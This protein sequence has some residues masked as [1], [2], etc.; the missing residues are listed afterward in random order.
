MEQKSHTALI[1]ED[2]ELN[3]EILQEILSEDYN[4]YTA[5]NG[6]EGMKVLR[7][8][9]TEIN[10][11]LLDIQMPVMNGYEVL[12]AVS[13][14]PQLNEIPIVVT[15]GNEES[16]E[17]LKCLKMGASDFIRKPY[18]PTLVLLRLGIIIH[19]SE[20]TKANMQK[21]Q[22]INNISHEIRTPLNAIMGF[23]QLLGMP[24]DVID[25]A[26][27]EKYVEVITNNTKMLLWM[28]E[29][30][31][32]LADSD[33]KMLNIVKDNT[34]IKTACKEA[35]ATIESCCPPE[36]E[37]NFTSDVGDDFLVNT[38]GNRVQQI[39]IKLLSN[40]C[41][42]TSEGS[43]NL[44]CSKDEKADVVT[45]SVSDSGPGVPSS[46]ADYIFERFTKLDAFK[47]GNGLGLC[48]ARQLSAML[49][50]KVYLDTEYKPGARFV[51]ELPL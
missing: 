34:S 4:V 28:I 45:I 13:E 43:I 32:I 33:N 26:D 17:E 40:A 2:N 23:S 20:S 44:H 19:L 50:G 9:R 25:D 38:D 31:L 51:L 35:V 7:E 8:H 42:W 30:A 27:R 39:L 6:L 22:F 24:G 36:V 1:I 5:E 37:L 49:G 10:V 11:I 14:D 18:N 21:T 3:S 47:P 12:K 16:E 41:K 46:K 29:D 48:I 15:T